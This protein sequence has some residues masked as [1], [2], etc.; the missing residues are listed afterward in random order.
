[1]PF[2]GTNVFLGGTLVGQTYLGDERIE[3]SPFEPQTLPFI[4]TDPSASFIVYAV[5]GTQ[6][7]ASFGQSSFRSDIS[8]YVRGNGSSF[9]DLPITGSGVIPYPTSSINNFAAQGYSTAISRQLTN[10]GG[11]AGS[12]TS[13]QFGSGEYT[14]ET[15]MN[16]QTYSS[17]TV[18]Y[19]Q[20][21]PGW[22]FLAPQANKQIR[23]VLVDSGGTEYVYNS[24]VQ[25][26]NDNTWY[27]IAVS[28]V[29]NVH[30]VYFN[31]N[32]VLNPTNSLTAGT[33]A[34]VQFMGVPGG[35]DTTRMQ[36][37]RVYKGKGKYDGATITL[38]E[39]MVVNA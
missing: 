20:Y 32:R 36:D 10:V 8:S 26:I 13:F 5:P 30:N 29:G 1:M 34:P 31:G 9:P 18:I 2:I 12:N 3:Y 28:R 27:H 25:T 37:F 39:S 33:T 4:R 24:G 6:F 11:I 19:W 14:I 35:M 7:S 15:W 23:L 21:S 38:P 22:G 16:I 17:G